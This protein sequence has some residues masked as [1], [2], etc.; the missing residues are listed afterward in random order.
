MAGTG[1]L[2]DRSSLREERRP[3]KTNALVKKGKGNDKIRLFS[4]HD[5]VPRHPYINTPYQITPYYVV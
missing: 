5:S 1:D 2:E 3:V 4:S